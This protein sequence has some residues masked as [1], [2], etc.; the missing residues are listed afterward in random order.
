MIDTRK[1]EPRMGQGS[2]RHTGMRALRDLPGYSRLLVDALKSPVLIYVAVG[3]NFFLLLCAGLFFHLEHGVNPQVNT[4]FDAIWWS[5]AT[6]TTVGY[7]DIHPMTMGGRIVAICLMVIG[8]MSFVSFA[9]LLVAIISARSMDQIVGLEVQETQ[10]LDS[11]I[12]GLL[13]VEQRLGELERRLRTKET[14]G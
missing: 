14:G 5:F 6:V 4:L 7:G 3:G 12:K 11:V 10:R 2:M 13:A 1:I 8:A 9:S